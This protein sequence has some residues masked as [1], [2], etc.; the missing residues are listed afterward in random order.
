MGFGAYAAHLNVSRSREP[1]RRS[2]TGEGT[3]SRQTRA[4]DLSGGGMRLALCSGVAVGLMAGLAP[5]PAV[6]QGTVEE[7]VVTARKREEALQDVP[8]AVTAYTS[9]QLD[10][11]GITN[12]I[13]LMGQ[14]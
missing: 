14:V 2:R 10:R 8:L 7:I 4:L 3:M 13:S 12:P 5:A 9:E 1:L 6:A 11:S